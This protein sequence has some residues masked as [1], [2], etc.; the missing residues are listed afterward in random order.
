MSNRSFHAP[1][2]TLEFAEEQKEILATLDDLSVKIDLFQCTDR[3][4]E[5]GRLIS[6]LSHISGKV[7]RI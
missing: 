6:R 1:A 5:Y 4:L 2:V 3:E 7:S